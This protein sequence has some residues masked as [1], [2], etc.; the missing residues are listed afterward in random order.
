MMRS[1][2]QLPAATLSLSAMSTSL[3]QLSVAVAV[4]VRAELLSSCQFTVASAGQVIAGDVLSTTVT[5]CTQLELLPQS[6]VAV[7][8]RVTVRSCGQLPAAKA[9][10]WLIATL[11]S[12][13]S[14]ALA[15]PVTA[16]SVLPATSNRSARQLASVMSAIHSI[17]VSA[18]QVIAG[19]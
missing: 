15:A 5:T 9:L 3:S 11:S 17:V 8:V 6:S 2:G 13:V 16:V 1:C 7:H 18:G 12:Q 10:L 14:V 4:P 19:A